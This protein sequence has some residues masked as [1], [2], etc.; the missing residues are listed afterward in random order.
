MKIVIPIA[1]GKLCLHFGHCEKFVLIEIDMQKKTIVN[2]TDLNPPPH[3]PGVLPQW[4]SK[5]GA[6]LIIAGGMGMR[7]QQFF[8]Q[9]GVDVVVG[10]YPD[11]PENIVSAY[12]NNSLQTGQNVCDH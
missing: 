5:E 10:A 4:L 9:Y 7:A 11:T 3:E 6:N 8:K 2:K 1:E 12:M